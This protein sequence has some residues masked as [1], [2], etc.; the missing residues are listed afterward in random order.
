MRQTTITN[1]SEQKQ[2][3]SNITGV[4]GGGAEIFQVIDVKTGSLNGVITPESQLKITGHNIKIAGDNPKN[5]ICFVRT[6]N[7]SYTDVKAGEII[8]NN[9]SELIITVPPLPSGRY[10]L[11]ITTQYPAG[12]QWHDSLQTAIFDKIL[13]VK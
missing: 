13:E 4:A 11:E 8:A 12:K 5:G 6:S 2:V 3:N 10:H 7:G 1:V 9:P